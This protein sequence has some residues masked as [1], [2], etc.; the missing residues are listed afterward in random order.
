M[1]TPIA[2]SEQADRAT[3]ALAASDQRVRGPLDE[4]AREH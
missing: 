1:L 4:Q 3:E 2:A